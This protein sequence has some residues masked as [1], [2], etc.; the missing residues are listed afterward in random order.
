MEF[1]VS[2]LDQN[3]CSEFLGFPSRIFECTPW[4]FQKLHLWTYNADT[5]PRSQTLN[6]RMSEKKKK[7]HISLAKG[8]FGLRVTVAMVSQIVS[9]P[10]FVDFWCQFWTPAIRYEFG[11]WINILTKTPRELTCPQQKRHFWGHDFP[12]LEVGYVSSLQLETNKCHKYNNSWIPERVW[13]LGPKKNTKNRPESWNLTP[14]EGLGNHTYEFW[15]C[16][17]CFLFLCAQVSHFVLDLVW[18]Y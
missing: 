4:R 14:L 2:H 13:N 15:L 18:V 8:H 12:F 1:G 3:P 16:N 10:S 11:F 9:Q 5:L 6:V 17:D 7:H